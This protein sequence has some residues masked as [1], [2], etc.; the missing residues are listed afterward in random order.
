MQWFLREHHRLWEGICQISTFLH[1]VCSQHAEH[2]AAFYTSLP[3]AALPH[4]TANAACS[5]IVNTE[6]CCCNGLSQSSI[7]PKLIWSQL[8]AICCCGQSSKAIDLLARRCLPLGHPWAAIWY[9]ICVM[10]VQYSNVK[11]KTKKKKHVLCEFMDEPDCPLVTR[12]R[13]S[14]VS[15]SQRISKSKIH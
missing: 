13:I 11:K 7:T 12:G 6:R 10:Q 1:Q 9:P 3:L 5:F 8:Y 2:Y 4:C 14:P 15:D